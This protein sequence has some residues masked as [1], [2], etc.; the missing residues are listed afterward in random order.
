MDKYLRTQFIL[1]SFFGLT[2]F[3]SV[4]RLSALINLP[5]MVRRAFFCLLG[6][7]TLAP[8]IAPAGLTVVIV[9]HGLLL[10]IAV[11]YGTPI[12]EFFSYY[13]W[14]P[15]FSFPSLGITATTLA[16]MAW[17]LV[18]AE[19]K[20]PENRWL[21]L[22][23]PVFLLF[24]VFHAYRY[25]YPDR[26]IPDEL[27]NSVVEKAYGTQ[28]DEV[29]NLLRITNLEEQRLEIARVK[30]QLEADPAI[31]SVTLY[32]PGHSS[33]I[34]ETFFYSRERKERQNTSCSNAT[35][36][37][38]NRLSRCTR[39]Y[40]RFD[41]SDLLGYKHP[42]DLGEESSI[43]LVYFEYDAAIEMLLN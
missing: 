34:G 28:L 5:L 2:A 17:R 29:A 15:H 32:E 39:K 26:D 41:R 8:M 7:L 14:L 40:G 30:A 25:E 16:L 1:E 3:F 38:R 33:V 21:A 9:P 6:T 4:W 37:H 24:G 19:A 31:V 36:K 27:D 20:P 18:K 22:A 12:G 43:V 35:K 11:D 23:L 42:Y 13:L 10:L